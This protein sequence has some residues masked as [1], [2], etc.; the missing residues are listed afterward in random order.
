MKAALAFALL[1]ACSREQPPAPAAVQSSSATPPASAAAPASVPE[2][3]PG[4]A[5]RGKKL[6]A[7]FE[8]NRCHDGTGLQ[9]A[10][11]ELHC[12]KC[13]QEIAAGTFKAPK[14]KL[15]EWR[16]HIRHVEDVPSLDALGAR[17]RRD[18]LVRFLQEPTDLRPHLAPSMP[19]MR[20]T[21]R[22]ARDLAAH[23]T[24][25][26]K[27]LPDLSLSSADLKQGRALMELKGC[28]TCHAMTGTPPL[29][30]LPNT[31]GDKVQS[32]VAL[33]PDLAHTR[34]RFRA[35][36]LVR[37]LRDPPAVKP[38]TLM[39][40][41]DL[42][43]TQARDV[44]RYL[45]EVPLTAP[46]VALRG[47]PPLLDRPV[48]FAEVDKRVFSKICRHCHGN[49]DIAGGDGGPGNTGGFGFPARKLDFSSY[50]GVASGMVRD[51][52][53]RHSIFLPL[54]DGTPR[55]VA[56]LLAR[57]SEEAGRPRKDVRGMPL[58]M[59]SLPDEDI[60]L[61]ATWVAQGRPR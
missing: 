39:P 47:A 50:S 54:D 25:D 51:D 55:L 59:P 17:V 61:V 58:G 21:E 2:A 43:E 44:A 40:S 52:G 46:K 15:A 6:V 26:A 30:L 14:K 33:A 28:G 60:Q 20:I 34:D 3:A 18:F 31:S 49:P 56:A 9:A 22:D 19:R 8:C 45:L 11:L 29:P 53:E 48:A 36:E 27:P 7:Q 35:A 41:F 10:K 38:G 1:V 37:W 23:L 12:F 16:P 13:H 42:T 24:R 32:A 57:R 4:D 5:E